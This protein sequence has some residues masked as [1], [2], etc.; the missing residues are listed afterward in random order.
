VPAD[1]EP[2]QHQRR[3][4]ETTKLSAAVGHGMHP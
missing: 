3:D 1:C 2:Q 4:G